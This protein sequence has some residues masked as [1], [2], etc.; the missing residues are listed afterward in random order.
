M[1]I[2]E[3]FQIVLDLAR[4]NIIEIEEPDEDRQSEQER[5]LEAL[6]MIEDIV[7]N[8]YGDD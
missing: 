3:A 8:G 1:D 5:Q 7:V 6:N 2:A 4:Q